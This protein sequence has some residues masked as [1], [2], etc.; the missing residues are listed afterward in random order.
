MSLNQKNL[1]EGGSSAPSLAGKE[2]LQEQH[3]AEVTRRHGEG[4]GSERAVL[5]DTQFLLQEGNIANLEAKFKFR[6]LINP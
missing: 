6:G 1:R 4:A 5:S 3:T 2:G